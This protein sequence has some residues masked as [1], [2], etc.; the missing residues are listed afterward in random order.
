MNFQSGDFRVKC[1]PFGF[2]P[3][4]PR[5]LETCYRVSQMTVVRDVTSPEL[6]RSAVWAQIGYVAVDTCSLS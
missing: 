3:S 6:A 1:L 5:R 2:A 4:R